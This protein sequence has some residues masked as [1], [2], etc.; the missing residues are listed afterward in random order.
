VINVVS[1]WIYF[2]RGLERPGFTTLCIS[3]R[4]LVCLVFLRPRALGAI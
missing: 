1:E 4:A 3:L 2:A